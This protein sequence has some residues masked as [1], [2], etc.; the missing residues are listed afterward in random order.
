[1]LLSIDGSTTDESSATVV[2]ASTGTVGTG[3][4]TATSV[5]VRTVVVITA[6]TVG[7]AAIDNDT[8]STVVVPINP[9]PPWLRE[10]P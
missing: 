7:G 4:D 2:T 3:D 6:G 1:M 10:Q 5:I 9:H 8:A